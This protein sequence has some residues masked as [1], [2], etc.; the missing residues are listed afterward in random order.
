LV[1]EV[2]VLLA[3]HASLYVLLNPCLPAQPAE[4]V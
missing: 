3:G 1:R 4:P 2:L